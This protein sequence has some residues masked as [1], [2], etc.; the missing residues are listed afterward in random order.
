MTEAAGA[1]KPLVEAQPGEAARLFARPEGGELTA[2]DNLTTELAA[3][4]ANWRGDSNY[5]A[6]QF[7]EKVKGW[8]GPTIPAQLR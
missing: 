7:A 3:E 4:T 8:W 6:A 1:A 2:A 5:T